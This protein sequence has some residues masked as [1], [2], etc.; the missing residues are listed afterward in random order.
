M[1]LVTLYARVSGMEKVGTLT[2]IGDTY[3]IDFNGEG[4][5]VNSL[6]RGLEAL[7]Q[8]VS[9][10]LK[11]AWGKDRLPWGLKLE[12]Q[13][14]SVVYGDYPRFRWGGRPDSRVSGTRSRLKDD[15][16]PMAAVENA[17]QIAKVMLKKG[18]AYG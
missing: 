17:I 5:S 14:A 18:G 3:K 16:P 8:L 6:N 15:A 9:G 4:G 2:R 1:I 11:T 12:M 7:K 10:Y 13:G